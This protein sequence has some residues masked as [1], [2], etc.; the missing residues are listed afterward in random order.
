VVGN[1][2][3]VRGETLAVMESASGGELASAITSVD[4]SSTYFVGGIVA[5]TRA[6]KG[7]FGVDPYTMDRYGLISA[8]T[9]CSMAGAAQR[10]FGSSYG[11]GITGIAGG[12]AVE[13]HPPG[14]CFIAV[15]YAD[16]QEAREL[17][18]PGSRESAK[19]WFSQ[20]ALDLL[21]TTMEYRRREQA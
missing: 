1:A 11:L 7:M 12:E 3:K 19:R 6:A 16:A 13:G 18:R 9:A 17:H 15:A 14:T 4:G 21:R 2:L 20:S 10:A 8:E 5:Y